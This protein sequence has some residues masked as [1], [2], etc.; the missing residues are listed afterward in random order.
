VGDGG[1]QQNVA[2]VAGGPRDR[3]RH[4]AAGRGLLRARL[5]ERSS[6]NCTAA[7]AE[8]RR[9]LRFSKTRFLGAPLLAKG[10]ENQ[11]RLVA[12]ERAHAQSLAAG[13]LAQTRVARVDKAG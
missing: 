4:R 2:R 7:S 12:L 13:R 5:R 1:R 10:Y 11:G 6:S 3:E 9:G 8:P